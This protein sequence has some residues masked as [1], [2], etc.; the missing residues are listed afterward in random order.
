M[1]Q[2]AANAV[3]ECVLPVHRNGSTFRD[4]CPRDSN[5]RVPGLVPLALRKGKN[6]HLLGRKRLLR[7]WVRIEITTAYTRSGE[8]AA[9]R[10]ICSQF[11]FPLGLFI[12][13]C[14]DACGNAGIVRQSIGD[15]NLGFRDCDLLVTWQRSVRVNAPLGGT[16]SFNS[17][18]P[19]D[20]LT[21]A[22]CIDPFRIASNADR[23]SEAATYLERSNSRRRDAAICSESRQGRMTNLLTFVRCLSSLRLCESTWVAGGRLRSTE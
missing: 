11:E 8:S 10:E 7:E 5:R 9:K 22:G 3:G 20:F 1:P 12:S 4:G 14:R 21:G 13:P 2:S 6:T 15:L 23:P 16:G 17:V 18:T 19:T